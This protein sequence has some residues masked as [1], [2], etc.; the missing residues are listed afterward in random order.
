MVSVDTLAS[1][2]IGTENSFNNLKWQ[3]IM[4]PNEKPVYVFNGT[5]YTWI[6]KGNEKQLKRN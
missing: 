6:A 1:G 5:R 2:S 3:Q 4:I